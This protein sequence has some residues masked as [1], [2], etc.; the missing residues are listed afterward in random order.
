MRIFSFINLLSSTLLLVMFSGQASGSPL[1]ASFKTFNNV[2]YLSPVLNGGGTVDTQP[3]AV[4]EW[5][6]L[7]IEDMSGGTLNSGDQ[8]RLKTQLGW[9]LVAEGGGG[10]GSILRADRRLAAAWET[11]TIEKAG[12]GRISSGSVVSLRL[13]GY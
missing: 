13:N 6:R 4:G 10:P 12:G 2:N 8:I 9:Y 5:E 3:S 7:T 11:F 1:I